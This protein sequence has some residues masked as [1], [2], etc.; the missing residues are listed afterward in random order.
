MEEDVEVGACLHGLGGAKNGE[1][2]TTFSELAG[3]DP[4]W[5]ASGRSVREGEMK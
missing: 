2:P 1:V 5:P 4:P 3:G